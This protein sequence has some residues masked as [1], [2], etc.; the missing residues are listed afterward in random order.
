MG[1]HPV[2]EIRCQLCS[3]PIDLN[4]DLSDDE[5]GKA[6]TKSVPSGESRRPMLLPL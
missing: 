3:K 4:T 1:G 6:F 5:N 2:P